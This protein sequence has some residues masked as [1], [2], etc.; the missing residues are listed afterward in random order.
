MK[1]WVNVGALLLL[2]SGSG[3]GKPESKCGPSTARVAFVVDGDTIELESGTKIR[4]LLADTTETTKGKNDCYGQEAATLNRTLVE[5]KTV[6]L[7]YDEAGC[8]DRFGRTLAY[9]TVDGVEVNSKLVKEGY[10]CTLFVS[11]SGGARKDEFETY[12][13]EAKTARIGLWGACTT[14]TCE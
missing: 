7:A 1:S 12:E 14:V 6:S 9:V 4:Y 10:A 11:P 8:T 2:L 13:S 5:G 3:C